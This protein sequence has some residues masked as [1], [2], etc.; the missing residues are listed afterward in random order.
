MRTGCQVNKAGAKASS[1][2]DTI[3]G[4][5]P[6][7]VITVSSENLIGEYLR[8]RR[9]LVLP[10][11]AGLPKPDPRRRV[12]GLRRAEVAMLAG[13]SP[14]YYMR[15][16]QGRDRHPSPRFSTRSPGRCSLTKTPQRT[17]TAWPSRK[18]VA[19]RVACGR[20][21]SRRTSPD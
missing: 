5:R 18:H 6:R 3:S 8:A 14:E 12:P 1:R 7:I 13:V 21:G 20:N 9:E 11:D 4:A 16:E 2:R 19:A 17:C 10:E 15:L